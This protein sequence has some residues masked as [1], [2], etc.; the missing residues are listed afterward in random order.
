MDKR[1][2]A[3]GVAAVVLAGGAF[4]WSASCAPAPEATESATEKA[5][6][7]ALT[8][9]QIERLGIQVKPAEDAGALPIGSV[10]A[11]VNL[12]PEARVA[13]TTPFAGTAV[14]VLV[15]Q[16][17]AVAK[18]QA[19]A[20]VRAAEPVQFG[21]ELARSE[22]DLALTRA[23]ANRLSQLAREG[24]VAGVRADEA[25]AALR[26]SE[27]SVRENRRLLALAGAG[28]DGTVTLRAP[29][30]GRVATAAI[31][32][33][34]AVGGGAAP[35]VIENTA[36]LRLDL[37]MPERM[38]GQVRPGMAVQVPLEGGATVT[39]KIL[40]VGA[41]LDPMTRSIAAKA[42]L[43]ASDGLV[44]GKGV[45]AV[46]GGASGASGVAVPVS[47]V[48]RIDGQDYVFVR[49]GN[50]FERRKV[51]VAIETGGR[52]VLS[53]GIRVGEQVAITGVTELK[54]LAGQ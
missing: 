4:W 48:T 7:H 8:A 39:G 37:Q 36:A 50:A 17:Q 5:G 23:N 51:A 49:K 54:S 10:P 21:A 42:S 30:A 35:F 20:V 18:G 3:G 38:A 22:A 25:S 40:S 33:G 41:S 47:A 29:I 34:A 1:I 12:P 31:E 19:L 9:A 14:Q 15:I 44:P 46:I 28:R 16:G 53:G 2:L 45:T 11:Q 24:V 52:A 43:S 6:A 13:V 26:R 32:T 27:A